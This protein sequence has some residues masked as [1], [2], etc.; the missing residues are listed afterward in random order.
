MGPSFS[1]PLLQIALLLHILASFLDFLLLVHSLARVRNIFSIRTAA[2]ADLEALTPSTYQASAATW[3]FTAILTILFGMK[4]FSRMHLHKDALGWDDLVL[5]ISWVR[6]PPST[7]P[8]AKSLTAST[9]CLILLEL[10]SSKRRST[11]PESSRPR[12]YPKPSRR[13]P[14][15]SFSPMPGPS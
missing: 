14:S 8:Q 12:T 7:A 1:L 3:P 10:Q 9:R 13:P 11:R 5:S 6:S 2:M 15:G 4:I